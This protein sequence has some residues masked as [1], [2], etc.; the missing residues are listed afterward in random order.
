[1]ELESKEQRILSSV[2]GLVLYA[3]NAMRVVVLFAIAL[4]C[5]GIVSIVASYVA[6]RHALGIEERLQDGINRL[7]AIQTR[8]GNVQQTAEDTQAGVA[9]AANKPTIDIEVRP[10]VSASAAHAS[11]KPPQA[12][13][14]IKPRPK[15]ST[16][17]SI[18]I[19][20]PLP[21]TSVGK[22]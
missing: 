12:Y 5:I 19:P 3:R 20:I 7:D 17:P 10:A 8:L 11:A 2:A 21:S 22:P 14:V 16:T 18:E 13:V 6:L 15:A 1:M 9:E 4:C